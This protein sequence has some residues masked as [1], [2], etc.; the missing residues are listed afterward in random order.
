MRAH[1]TLKVEV[2]KLIVLIELKELAELGIGEDAASVLGVLK[3]VGT[4]I[5]VNLASDLG[6]GHLSSLGLSEESGELDTNLS[7]LYKATRSTVTGLA[8]LATLLLCLLELTVGTLG[9]GANLAGYRSELRTKG[10]ELSEKSRKLVPHGRRGW[11]GGS[12]LLCGGRS[13]LSLGGGLG[14]GFLGRFLRYFLRGHLMNYYI[15]S[16]L[17]PLETIY[18][19]FFIFSIKYAAT[20]Y[21]LLLIL[22]KRFIQPR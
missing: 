1:V 14:G 2:G 7:G 10:S 9:K 11:C 6:A 18:I 21:I 8:F 13:R 22:N 12:C 3:L 15:D 19:L 17:S 4:N 20:I 5:R 16:F